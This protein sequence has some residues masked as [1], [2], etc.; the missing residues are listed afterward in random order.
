LPD[1]EEACVWKVPGSL[2]AAA[3]MLT[4][5]GC[6]GGGGGGVA[7]SRAPAV[8]GSPTSS[9]SSG[10]SESAQPVGS[11]A[12]SGAAQQAPVKQQSAAIPGKLK[13]TIVL[14]VSAVKVRGKLATVD[15]TITP[16][17]PDAAADKSFSLFELNGGSTVPHMTLVDPV[18]L[19]RYSVVKD[20]NEMALEPDVVGV[21]AR[22]G[23][24]ASGTY[25]FAA[26]APGV[27]SI[28]VYFSD[29]PPFRDVPVTR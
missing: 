16:T 9:P 21:R 7:A 25:T 15:L 12:P 1:P 3:L 5:T 2:V 22:S 17:L 11:A 23:A 6:S 18:G 26:P 24:S 4:L 29:F 10:S 27:T 13:G 19:K 28:D 20:A 14:G 8:P